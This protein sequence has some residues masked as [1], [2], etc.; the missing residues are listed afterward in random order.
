MRAPFSILARGCAPAVFN[1]R[2][3]ATMFVEL[4]DQ[5]RCPRAHEQSWLVAS[6]TRTDGRDIME[7]LL[8]CP[9][10]RA[11]YPITRGIARFGDGARDTPALPPDEAEAMRL[12]ALLD[13]AEPRGYV[14][15][16]GSF[17]SHARLVQRLTDVHLLLVD[18]P[19]DLDMGAGISGV[20]IAGVLP[21]VPHSAHGAALDESATPALVA[22]AAE[23]VRSGGRV[24]APVSLAVP[25]GVAELV[26]DGRVWVGECEP[27]IAP[28]APIELQ[29]SRH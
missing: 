8:G 5:L 13:L 18:P 26:R 25:P 4:I 28:S 10:C 16:T 19:A 24:V 9:V 11:E 20:T 12:A 15:L 29:R 1:A 2:Q 3:I 7:G 6:A 14:V 21:L 17:G 23:V 22:S 27:G